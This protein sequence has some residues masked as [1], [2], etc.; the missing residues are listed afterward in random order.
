MKR[1]EFQAL[2]EDHNSHSITQESKLGP[3]H[4]TSEVFPSNFTIFQKD[5]KAGGGG[6]FIMLRDYIEYVEWA[7]DELQTDNEMV[8]TQLKLPGTNLK[9]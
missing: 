8:W 2:L 4:P 3:E 5:R 6:I 1:A 7:F 9:F